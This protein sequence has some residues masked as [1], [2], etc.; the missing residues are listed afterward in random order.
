MFKE[1]KNVKRFLHPWFKPVYNTSKTN[2]FTLETSGSDSLQIRTIITDENY[3]MMSTT[4]S[5]HSRQHKS[6][7]RAGASIWFENWGIMGLGL[8]TGD[9]GS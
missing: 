5:C 2:H 8:K 6:L 9:R 1:I 7:V 3:S 4:T